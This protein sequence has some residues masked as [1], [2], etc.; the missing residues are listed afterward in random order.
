MVTYKNNSDGKG[1][2]CAFRQVGWSWKLID[3][4]CHEDMC[5]TTTERVFID[6][7]EEGHDI[8]PSV[9]LPSPPLPTS[10]G[11][12]DILV[13]NYREEGRKG[14]GMVFDIAKG[15]RPMTELQ[16]AKR[17]ISDTNDDLLNKEWLRDVTEVWKKVNHGQVQPVWCGVGEPRHGKIHEREWERL[18]LT[19]TDLLENMSPDKLRRWGIKSDLDRQNSMEWWKRYE[20]KTV[21]SMKYDTRMSV[22]SWRRNQ[23]RFIKHQR[24]EQRFNELLRKSHELD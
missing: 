24:E 19:L 10:Q 21:N 1:V 13:K 17:T 20:E 12:W 22:E 11:E 6:K 5:Q 14:R 16:R 18:E 15:K 3:F 23:Q 8:F 7:D 9:I 2:K 4:A